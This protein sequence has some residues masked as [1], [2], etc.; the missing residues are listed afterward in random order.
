VCQ[1]DIKVTNKEKKEK[2][3]EL[4]LM[5]ES[6]LKE[7]PPSSNNFSVSLSPLPPPPGI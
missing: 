4:S 2:I 3:Q 6:R 5:L 1:T 7:N